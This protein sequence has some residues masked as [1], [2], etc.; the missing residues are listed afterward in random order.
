MKMCLFCI[1]TFIG[2]TKPPCNSKLP[3]RWMLPQK[4]HLHKCDIIWI[5]TVFLWYIHLTYFTLTCI[6]STMI[7]S[8]VLV[9]ICL[10]F[11][12]VVFLWCSNIHVKI[13]SAQS[14]LTLLSTLSTSGPQ[15]EVIKE[16]YR[17][18]CSVIFCGQFCTHTPGCSA[19][20]VRIWPPCGC[21][22]MMLSPHGTLQNDDLWEFYKVE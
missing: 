13:F 17:D 3:L 10:S 16:I 2:L 8:M 11:V 5:M 4:A 12:I 14:Q 18:I 20:Y 22:L 9:Y 7:T 19:I 21:K 6:T 1:I 15:Y